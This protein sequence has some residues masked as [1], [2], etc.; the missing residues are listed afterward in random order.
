MSWRDRLIPA[1]FR[2]AAFHVEAHDAELGRRVQVHEFP[3]RD[4]AYAEDLGRATRRFSLQAYVLGDDYLDRRDALVRAVEQAGAGKLDHPYLGEMQATCT[5]CRV[6]ETTREG[7][8]CRFSLEFVEAGDAALVLRAAQTSS[9]AVARRD[10]ALIAAQGAFTARHKVAGQPEFVAAAAQGQ[11]GKALDTMRSAA[12]QVRAVAGKVAQL[13]RAV[14]KAKQDLIGIVYEPAAAAQAVLGNLRLL[15][16]EVAYGP[17]EA[18]ALARSFY[19][20]NLDLLP[21]Q[22]STPARRQQ[23]ANQA[24]MGHLV[25]LGAAAEAAGAAAVLDFDSYQDA[26]ATR[27]ELVEVLDALLEDPLLADELFDPVRALR[28]ATVRDITARGADLARSLPYTP[29]TTLPALVIAH[30]VYSD[31]RRDLE[32]VTR[33]AIPHPGFVAGQRALEVLADG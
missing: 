13:A 26:D 16:R 18:L 5:A 8:M 22:G 33:N 4:T 24:A 27:T 32:L 30:Q 14:T 21:P 12:G 19:S 6:Q 23:A 25:R 28:A 31:S 7:G 17:R 1:A 29:R 20:F 10:E 9:A 3:L 2:G 11:L 15:V